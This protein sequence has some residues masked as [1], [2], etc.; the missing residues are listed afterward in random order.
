MTIFER[1]YLTVEDERPRSCDPGPLLA[2]EIEGQ[3]AVLSEGDV[4]ELSRA[5]LLWW[6]KSTGIETP[7]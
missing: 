5:L 4:L 2:F 3:R 6:R 7:L 1:D